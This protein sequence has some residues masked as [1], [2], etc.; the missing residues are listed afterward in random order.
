[1][2]NEIFSLT[3]QNIVIHNFI[4]LNYFQTLNVRDYCTSIL[5]QIQVFQHFISQL[6]GQDHE[7]LD[8]SSSETDVNV[9][10]FL[11]S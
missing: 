5:F 10:V 4:L 8:L 7:H 9:I 6:A 2:Y 11:R 3:F 1:M